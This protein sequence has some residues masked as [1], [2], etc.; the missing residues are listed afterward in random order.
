LNLPRD[1]AA[2]LDPYVSEKYDE[3]WRNGRQRFMLLW[4]LADGA[5]AP[6][7]LEEI[8][9]ADPTAAPKLTA[10]RADGVMLDASIDAPHGFVFLVTTD[11]DVARK[12]DMHTEDEF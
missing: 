3:L 9:A 6:L 10:M 1:F 7:S 12:Y 4:P 5:A 8:A 11:P 2:R